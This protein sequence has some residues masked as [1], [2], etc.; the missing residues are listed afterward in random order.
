MTRLLNAFVRLNFPDEGDA[1]PLPQEPG[2]DAS[3]ARGGRYVQVCD[4][5]CMCMGGW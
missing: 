4:Y 5:V 2:K 1:Q 3:A